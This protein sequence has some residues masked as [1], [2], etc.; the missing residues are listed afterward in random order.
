MLLRICWQEIW[1]HFQLKLFTGWV[2]MRV[3]LKRLLGFIQ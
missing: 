1:W 3:T 2:Q